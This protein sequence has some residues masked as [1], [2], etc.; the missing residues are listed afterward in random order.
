M[1]RRREGK[2]PAKIWAIFISQYPSASEDPLITGTLFPGRPQCRAA[3]VLTTEVPET[4]KCSNNYQVARKSF[5]PGAF[6]ICC[7]CENP[8]VLGVFI[9]D[10]RE[11]PPA[12][13]NTIITRFALL[14]QH[15]I[16]NFG[17]G[18]VHSALTKLPWLLCDCTV[19]SDE[20][21]VVNHVCSVSMDPRYFLTLK[22]DSTGAHE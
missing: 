21:H 13:L 22:K 8:R 12:L 9:L 7:A 4:G 10:K 3:A 14:P 17:C 11:G 6:L 5:T 20:F 16:Y 15:I 18:A 1:R 19:S 2:T